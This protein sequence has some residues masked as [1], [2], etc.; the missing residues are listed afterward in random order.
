MEEEIETLYDKMNQ[1]IS[2]VD[3]IG[4]GNFKKLVHELTM[5]DVPFF[6]IVDECV[7]DMLWLENEED[8]SFQYCLH[9]LYP[10]LSS[11]YKNRLKYHP[12][13]K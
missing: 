2:E 5:A 10:S 3:M 9:E 12:P 13:T 11:Y 7:T 1:A 8:R 6:P 4:E